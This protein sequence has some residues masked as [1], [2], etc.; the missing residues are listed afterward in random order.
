MHLG[1]EIPRAAVADHDHRTRLAD[2]IRRAA[3][4]TANIANHH[5]A[6]LHWHALGGETSCVQ[7]SQRFVTRHAMRAARRFQR[8]VAVVHIDEREIDRKLERRRFGRIVE[9][10]GC[11]A[12]PVLVLG[13][14]NR[15]IG[16]E[17]AHHRIAT[18]HALDDADDVFIAKDRRVREFA[19]ERQR[20]VV[21]ARPAIAALRRLARRFDMRL[22]ERRKRIAPRIERRTREMVA[23]QHES[24]SFEPFGERVSRALVVLA[25]ARSPRCEWKTES[26]AC[27]SF[28]NIISNNQ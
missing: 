8:T 14:G 7:A 21:A 24:V 25:H 3:M 9:Q 4:Q 17:L 13:A 19:F 18:G 16:R 5:V 2:Q 28:V 22:Q 20:H 6:D 23:Q 10:C 15:R 11:I 27:N 1:P 12:M 26:H